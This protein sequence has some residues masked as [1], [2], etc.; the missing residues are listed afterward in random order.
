MHVAI[1][2]ITTGA[3]AYKAPTVLDEVNFEVEP[4]EYEARVWQA[5]VAEGAVAEGD[6]R[7]YTFTLLQ[8]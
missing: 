3:V 1:V 7:K 8:A 2:E 6:R 4:A 5:A